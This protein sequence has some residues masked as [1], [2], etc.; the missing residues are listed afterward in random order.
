[1]SLTEPLV[2]GIRIVL[3]MDR[4]SSG[5]A[6]VFVAALKDHDIAGTVGERTDGQG[7]VQDLSSSGVPENQAGGDSIGH[8]K[9][10]QLFSQSTMVAFESFL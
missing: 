3:L 5:A 7:S 9:K 8:T 4:G 10:V 1:M 2:S 6:E